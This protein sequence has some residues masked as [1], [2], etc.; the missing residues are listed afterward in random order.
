MAKEKTKVYTYTRV[1]TAIQT[2]RYFPEDIHFL[3]QTGRALKF[4]PTL[5]YNGPSE[6]RI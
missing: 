3:P 6:V 5:C 4:P 1:S 2:D